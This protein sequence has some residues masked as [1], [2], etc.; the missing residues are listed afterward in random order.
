MDLTDVL[1]LNAV[2]STF[3]S[4]IFSFVPALTAPICSMFPL[5]LIY[6]VCILYDPRPVLNTPLGFFRGLD[7]P[8]ECL[9]NGHEYGDGKYGVTTGIKNTL[10]EYMVC[11]VSEP[12]RMCVIAHIYIFQSANL[13]FWSPTPHYT[14]SCVDLTK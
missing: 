6:T 13:E 12:V 5:L 11:S 7:T 8:V 1:F 2:L 9:I 4:T 10:H 3:F 14:T